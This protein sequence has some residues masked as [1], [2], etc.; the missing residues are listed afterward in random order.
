MVSTITAAIQARPHQFRHKLLKKKEFFFR[1]KHLLLTAPNK[2]NTSYPLRL[3]MNRM[4]K[5]GQI[6]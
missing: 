5:T 2:P 6:Q 3:E 1:L 4:K